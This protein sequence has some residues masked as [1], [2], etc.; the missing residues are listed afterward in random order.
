MTGK[1]KLPND[2]NLQSN[3]YPYPI[4]ILYRLLTYQHT[5]KHFHNYISK[6]KNDS[7]FLTMNESKANGPGLILKRSLLLK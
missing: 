2:Y 5:K 6:L 1:K 7:N 4:N 3:T